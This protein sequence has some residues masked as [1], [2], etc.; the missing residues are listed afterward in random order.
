[1]TLNIE[2]QRRE[3]EA[4]YI[5]RCGLRTEDYCLEYEVEISRYTGDCEQSA[6]EGWLAAKRAAQVEADDDYALI[7]KLSHLLAGVV[8]AVKGE[9]AP[10]HRHSYH[11]IVEAVNILKLEC[12]MHRLQE[13]DRRARVAKN[14][15]KEPGIARPV[16]VERLTAY[17]ALE[18]AVRDH[19][20]M[21]QNT[22]DEFNLCG[23]A[24]LAALGALESLRQAG[25]ETEVNSATASASA[26]PRMML[27]GGQS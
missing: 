2:Q 26:V 8:V 19:I 14:P 27:D 16:Q 7:E 12:D 15:V 22:S 23:S 9:E 1:M 3:F 10:L 6:W 13:A 24:I 18:V 20:A 4:D 5:D 11:D 17:Q 21:Y 25:V